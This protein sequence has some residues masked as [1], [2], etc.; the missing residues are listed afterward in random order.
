MTCNMLSHCT[1]CGS[2]V[3]ASFARV[4][5]DRDGNVNHCPHCRTAEATA[6]ADGEA[7]VAGG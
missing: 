2:A 5:A 4:F 3:T 6:K 7:G 1:H